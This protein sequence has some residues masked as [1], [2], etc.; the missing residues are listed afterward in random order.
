[1][2][3]LLAQ[4]APSLED[5]PKIKDFELIFQRI[6]TVALGFAGVAV[7][8]MFLIGGFK[9]LTSGGDPKGV[10]EAQKTITYAVGGLILIAL[11]YLILVLIS[12]FT[13]VSLTTFTITK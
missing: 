6:L 4:A 12:S 2:S 10:E 8:I 1:M 7:F 13:G 5:V 11:S 3:N 9:Y